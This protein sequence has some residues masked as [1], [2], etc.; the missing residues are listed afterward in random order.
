MKLT[1]RILK[2]KSCQKKRKSYSKLLVISS[3]R[4]HGRFSDVQDLSA[5]LKLMEAGETPAEPV[6]PV[7]HH[8]YCN[9]HVAKD[10]LIG[11]YL[12]HISLVNLPPQLEI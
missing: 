3:L 12:N 4:Q 2:F 10:A 1:T 5:K 6:V 8:I 7:D 11:K 9:I